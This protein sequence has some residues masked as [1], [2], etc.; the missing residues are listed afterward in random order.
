MKKVL[1]LLMAAACVTTQVYAETTAEIKNENGKITVTGTAPEGTPIGVTVKSTDDD[2]GYY[3]I[4]ETVSDGTFE[5]EF[6]LRDRQTESDVYE[7]LITVKGDS[8]VTQKLLTISDPQSYVDK[9]TDPATDLEAL[10]ANETDSQVY[11]NLGFDSDT[12]LAMSPEEQE[13]VCEAFKVDSRGA[14]DEKIIEILN[15]EL[16]VLL[17]TKAE[18]I[19]SYNEIMNKISGDDFDYAKI[20]DF[21]K[22]SLFKEKDYSNIKE[23]K[24]SLETYELINQLNNM[25]YSQIESAIA[26]NAEKLGLENDARYIKYSSFIDT[27]KRAANE[28]LVQELYTTPATSVGEFKNAFYRA[29][30]GVTVVSGNVNGGTSGGSSGGS[31]GGGYAGGSGTTNLVGAATVRDNVIEPQTAVKKVFE[32]VEPS[33]W[34]ADAIRELSEKKIVNGY[35]DETFKPNNSI[36]REEFVTIIVNAFG[37]KNDGAASDFEDVSSNDWFYT[38][39]SSAV[40]AGIVSGISDNSFGTGMNITRQDVAVLVARALKAENGVSSESFADDEEISAYAS[41]SVYFLKNAGIISGR[42]GNKFAPGDECTRA[43]CAVIIKKAL[44]YSSK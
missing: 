44:E 21:V 2:S 19:V 22:E 9:L 35:D 10:L 16:F 36:T 33:F 8:T 14:E 39:V 43:E 27:Y 30:D 29:V 13:K 1:S 18:T 3:A 7:Y 4:R 15:K 28:K 26:S 24:E 32:D 5:L 11:K 31:S 34:A 12:Y 25:N 23:L 37:L 40:G 41:D 17:S 6:V 42:D 20:S 38:Y